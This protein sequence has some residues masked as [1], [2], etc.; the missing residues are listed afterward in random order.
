[1]RYL[2]T[3][4]AGFIGSNFIRFLFNK[5]GDDAQVVNLDK[6]TYAGIRENLAE[7]EGRKNYRFV[8]GDIAVPE[9]V[10][11]GYKGVDGSGVD[12]VVNFAAETH[13]DRSLMEAATFIQTDVQGVLVLLE[14]AKKHAPNLKRFIQISTDE[15][16]GSI[17]DGS[18]TETDPLNPRNPYSASKAGGDRMAY[19][20]AQTFG[21]PVIVTR[22]SNN[23]GPFQYPEKLIPLFVTNA[24]DDLSLPLYG[25]GKNVR[26]WLFVDDHCA[27]VDF[28]IEHGENSEVYN[29][30]GGNE[31]ENREI[32]H[33]ILELTGKPE[34]LIKP[35]GDRQGHDRRYSLDTK[36]LEALG[37]KANTDFDEALER[38]VRWYKDHQPW[39]RAIKER[40]AEYKAYYEKQY[41]NR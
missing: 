34:S 39:W 33:R 21:M 11:E 37:F 28:L 41:A 6:L 32:T 35:V 27:A 29:I 10:A 23:F 13:V 2:V 12:V 36:K 14:E 31:R 17:D 19:A 24:M 25:D 3:G 40:S 16:Y 1:M 20:Y 9:D 30:G 8:Q 15:V 18:F 7:Y 22:A 38:T 5:Y 4:G 26:D